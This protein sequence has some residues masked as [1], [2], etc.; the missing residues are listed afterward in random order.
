MKNIHLIPVNIS[1]LVDKLTSDKLNENEEYNY[2]V[3]LETIRDYITISLNTHSRDK[4]SLSNSKTRNA[5]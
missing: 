1:D 5:R 4:Q 3:R 2:R